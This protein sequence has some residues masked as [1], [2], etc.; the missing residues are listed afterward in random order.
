M[1][2]KEEILDEI[3]DLTVI[4]L[5]ELLERSRKVRSPLPLRS[6]SPPLPALAA[7]MLLPTR[8]RTSST[9]SSPAPG[10]RRSRSS[11]SSASFTSL[12]LKEAKDLVDTAPKAV[13]EKATKEAAEAANT[14]L[15]DAG[16]SVELKKPRRSSLRAASDPISGRGPPMARWCSTLAEPFFAPFCENRRIRLDPPDACHALRSAPLGS[17]VAVR[18]LCSCP[19]HECCFAR[20]RRR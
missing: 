9:S 2:T 13:L 18:R 17:S 12:G 6:P 8:S 1:P 20:P 14:K 4:E 15:E 5:K 3:C 16:A 19:L 10:P 11:R 7:A